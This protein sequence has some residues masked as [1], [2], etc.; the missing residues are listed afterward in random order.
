LSEYNLKVRRQYCGVW[1]QYF[2]VS[3]QYLE[4]SWQYMEVSIPNLEVSKFQLLAFKQVSVLKG[5]PISFIVSPEGRRW[6]LT[7]GK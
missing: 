4:V 6:D 5:A 2:E 1:R 7:V 3:G